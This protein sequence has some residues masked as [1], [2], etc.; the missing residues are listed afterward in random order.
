M[1]RARFIL[2][3]GK[4]VYITSRRAQKSLSV[5]ADPSR[6]WPAAAIEAFVPYAGPL[7]CPHRTLRRLRAH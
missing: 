5:P 6:S 2:I 3:R 4:H 1:A 7:L